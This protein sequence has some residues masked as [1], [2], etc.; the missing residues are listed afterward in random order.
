VNIGDLI[1]IK[2]FLGSV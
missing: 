1:T 2:H